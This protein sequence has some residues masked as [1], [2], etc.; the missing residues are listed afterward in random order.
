M[1][2]IHISII[3]IIFSVLGILMGTQ[4]PQ[5]VSSNHA[6]EQVLSALRE[7]SVMQQNTPTMILSPKN[8]RV[9][10]SP[11]T[12]VPKT[13]IISKIKVH[14]PIEAVGLDATGNMATPVNADNAGWYKLGYKLGQK[15]NAVFAG[16]YDKS[17]GA[18]A[19]FW[20]IPKLV[21]GDKIVVIDTVGK[22]YTYVISKKEKYPYN[23]FPIEKVFGAAAESQLNLITCQGSWNAKTKNYSERMVIFARLSQ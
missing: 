6:K 2:K 16:H 5:I 10:S 11:E 14:A 3:V 15:G 23:E 4:L 18:P 1:K 20:N 13:L 17:T 8:N 21:V 19:I 9:T 22:E 7:P 12:G